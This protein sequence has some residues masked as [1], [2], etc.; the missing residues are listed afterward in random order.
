MS[1]CSTGKTGCPSP[2]TLLPF[3]NNIVFTSNSINITNP[4]D[5]SNNITGIYSC[6]ASSY[7]DN[8]TYPFNAFNNDNTF[9]KSNTS[10]NYYHFPTDP[11]SDPKL[12]GNKYSTTP[13]VSTNNDSSIRSISTYQGGSGSIT[14]N[15]FTTNIVGS[16]IKNINGEWLQIQF[17]IPIVLTSYSIFTPFDD[18][19]KYFPSKF[20]IVA[21]NDSSSKNW[22]IIDSSDNTMVSSDNI[23]S[24]NASNPSLTFSINNNLN[25]YSCYRLIIES[26][27]KGVTCPRIVKW[28]LIGIPQKTT[29][30]TESFIGMLNP[31]FHNFYPSLNHFSNFAISEPLTI[32]NSQNDENNNNKNVDYDYNNIYAGIIFAILASTLVYIYVK[33]TK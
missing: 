1:S 24:I 23:P 8:T 10:E 29:T 13:Y 22:T 9:W 31:Q 6:S 28:K 18:K 32:L 11:K 20:T 25:P 14:E 3:T 15:Y 21:S 33:K 26:L 5:N 7:Y 2:I 12:K 17:P 27:Q 16:N 30:T 4:I 19:L